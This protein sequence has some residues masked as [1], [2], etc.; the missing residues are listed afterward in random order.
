MSEEMTAPEEL[1][2]AI[3]DAF[4]EHRDEELNDQDLAVIVADRFA[5]NLLRDFAIAYVRRCVAEFRAELI[6]KFRREHGLVP[7]FDNVLDTFLHLCRHKQAMTPEEIADML[8]KFLRRMTD[9]AQQ[10]GYTTNPAKDVHDYA[11][12]C[13]ATA[14]Q[15]I[16][17]NTPPTEGNSQHG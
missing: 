16:L 12:M 2:N 6:A 10:Q 15:R 4:E 13:C 7:Y 1:W 3:H 11:M 5:D 17:A 8:G 14:T 9:I